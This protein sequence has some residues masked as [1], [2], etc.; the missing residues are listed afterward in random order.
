MPLF[1]IPF[2]AIDPVAIAIG[3]VAIRW[4]AL[5]Y[6]GSLLLGWRYCLALADRPP[7]FVRRRD[8][9]DF[10]VWATLGIVL[11]GRLGYV[12]FYNSA[13]YLAH[14]IEALYLWY[15]GMSFHGGAL[16]VTL[17][18]WAFGRARGIPLLAFADIVCAAVPIGLF[19]GRIANFINGELF[20]R[21]S[22]V[23]WAMVF[24]DAYKLHSAVEPATRHPSQLYEAALEG[25]ALFF[26][27]R[28]LTHRYHKLASPGFVSGGFAFG[29]GLA[30]TVSEF[31]REPDIQIG[32]LAGGITMGMLLS[33]PMILFGIGLMI[34]SARRGTPA[35][36][37]A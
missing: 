13:Y 26:F 1:A 8:I 23:P 19:F 11:G 24:P 30:R 15:G 36:T 4:Y 25:V 28:L 18:I 7:H 10:L 32:Y 5:A 20:G 3:P 6:I 9:D 29:Y 33:I 35:V 14:P 21:Q 17:A 37:R 34:W 27:L 22:D 12:L 16:G 31:F 2:P